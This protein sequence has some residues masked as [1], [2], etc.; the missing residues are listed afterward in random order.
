MFNHIKENWQ[1][2]AGAHSNALKI[3]Q[4][5]EEYFKGPPIKHPWE[6]MDIAGLTQLQQLVLRATADIPY[7]FVS[8]YK[9]IAKAIHRPHA[10]HF[11]GSALA[12]NPFPILIPCYRVIPSDSSLG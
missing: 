3:E 11:A 6:W 2:K 1:A 10:Y 5:I 7:G 12:K 9:Q 4:R 8:S